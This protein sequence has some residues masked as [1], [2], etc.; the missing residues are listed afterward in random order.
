MKKI[1]KKIAL[2]LLALHLALTFQVANAAPI[3]DL[4]DVGK[5]TGLPSFY[6]T[7]Q[8]PDALP[9]YAQD[10][11]GTAT[12]P[13]FFFIDFFRLVL[14]GIAVM[15]I[16][17]TAIKLVSVTSEEEAQKAKDNLVMAIVGLLIVQFA[18]VAVKK[19]FFGEQGEAFQDIAT[20]QI[21]ANESVRQFRGVIGFVQ[22][23]VGSVAVLMIVYRGFL[24]LT[25]NGDEEALTKAKNHIVYAAL[26]LLMVVISE[27]VLRG[28][29]FPEAGKELPDINKGRF[30]I[31]TLTNYIAGFIASF[32]FATLFYGG[33][34]YVTSA[35]NEEE[36][37]R[38]KK[39]ILS[40]VI[41]L[42]LSLGAFA[43][44]NTVLKF[45]PLE[46]TPQ[47]S[48]IEVVEPGVN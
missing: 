32:S 40:A 43:L 7:G 25:A 45:E 9:D 27:V 22:A 39:I 6:E 36:T 26:G 4:T 14:S 19:M 46:D 23:F 11:I 2:V 1:F 21:Y 42:V 8:H 13:I 34:R 44:I 31:V 38:V 37:E 30:I 24:L 16:A 5:R 33:Y 35:G 10:G 48:D 29:V 20:V 41:A 28:V 12:S 3:D 15:V 17:I 18:D 47:N